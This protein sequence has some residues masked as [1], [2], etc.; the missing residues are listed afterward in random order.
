[1]NNRQIDSVCAR[2]PSLRKTYIGCYAADTLRFPTKFPSCCILNTQK[3]AVGNG[4]WVSVWFL[5]S[6]KVLFFDPLGAK[7]NAEHLKVLFSR[8]TNIAYNS[9]PVQDND[10]QACA[11][12]AIFFL[13]RYSIGMD[14][15]E[16]IDRF[17]AMKDDDLFVIGW[18]RKHFNIRVPP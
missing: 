5:N 16:I 8:F 11:P 12:F 2:L 1:M 13:Y 9:R 4:H 14:F 7:P 15:E 6:S 17:S 10:T 18:I 3:L